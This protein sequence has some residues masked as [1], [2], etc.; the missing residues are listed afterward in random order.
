LVSFT[1]FILVFMIHLL[2]GPH[3][4]MTSDGIFSEL[5]RIEI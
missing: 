2:L 1:S 4:L 3:W 5:E